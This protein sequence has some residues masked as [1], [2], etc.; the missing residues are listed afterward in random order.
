M[1]AALRRRRG[2][3]RA[4]LLV[5]AAIVI[6]GCGASSPGADDTQVRRGLDAIGGIPQD[7]FTLG[8][9]KARETLIVLSRPTSF[10][11]DHLITQLPELTERLVRPGLLKV[12]LRMPTTGAYGAGDDERA[13]AGALLAA[14]RQKR[15]WQ[16]VVRFVPTHSGRV[17]DPELAKLLRRS[18]VPDPGRA[19]TERS[20]STVLSALD[21]A[22]A[23]ATAIRGNGRVVYM[24]GSEG[25]NLG[26]QVA[27]G[28]RISQ[29]DLVKQ[30]G[31]LSKSAD[32]GM[33]AD[34]IVRSM[35]GDV[36]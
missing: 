33:L 14:G 8:D 10:E 3:L 36:G 28:D 27:G 29:E 13:V 25:E 34:A 4:A 12:Q 22:D 15:F 31:V 16:A 20:S 6:A 30:A 35:A 5:G 18:G 1:L 17:G 9:P 11:L 24:L 23:A 19:M 7:G 2:V 26:R 32:R 21:E